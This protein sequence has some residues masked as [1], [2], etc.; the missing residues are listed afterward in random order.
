MINDGY[1]AFLFHQ[2]TNYR[3]YRYLGNQKNND[4]SVT[5]R[6]W[7]PNAHAV[8]LAGEFNSWSENL[9]LVRETKDGVWTYRAEPGLVF[10]NSK[11]KYIIK[12]NGKSVYKSDP[13][14]FRSENGGGNASIVGTICEFRWTDGKYIERRKSL[15]EYLLSHEHIPKPMNIYE[16]HLGSWK[17][18]N[19]DEYLNYRELADELCPYL[20]KM[21]YTH[22]ELM[23]IMEHPF[24]GSWGY[25]ICSYFSPTARFGTP[26][27]FAYLINK[28]HNFGIGVILDW[29]PAH[30]PKDEHG[31]YEYDGTPL[32]EYQGSD[33]MEHRGWGTRVFDVGRNEVQSF[34]ISNALYWLEEFHIDGLRVDAVASMLYLDYDKMPGEWNPNPDGSKINIQAVEFFKKLNTAVSNDFPDAMMIAEES[35]DWGAITKPVSKGGLGFHY[36]WDMGWMND[37][38]SYVSE[39]SGYRKYEHKK[40]TFSMMYSFGENYILPISHDEVVHGK[41]SLLDKMSGDYWQKFATNRA[42][43]GYMMTHPGKK[44]LFMGCEYGQFREW[45]YETSLEWFMLSYDLHSKLSNYVKDLNRLY[46]KQKQLW[47]IDGSWDGF[48]WLIADDNERSIIAFERYGFAKTA[49]PLVVVINFQPIAYEGFELPVT[50]KGIYVEILNSDANEYGGSGVINIG[51]I[52]SEQQ[53]DFYK[54]KMRLPPLG[55]S[56]LKLK[57]R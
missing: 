15:S 4:G 37:S 38:L 21:G 1:A 44:L 40:L 26:E 35:T 7:A 20:L 16:V 8:F 55:I 46:L 28:L 49:S 33:R 12:S 29:V 31:L 23:P 25:Q 3:A 47:Q 36:K 9:P 53:G 54:V 5:F 42:F 10:D 14:A 45:D 6:V 24:D 30:F 56:I 52:K 39:Y 2:G 57:G 41:K 48:R 32:Y 11:Y 51:E 43:L 34:L 17:R 13:Y 50:K 27:D 19:G 22:I 18:K